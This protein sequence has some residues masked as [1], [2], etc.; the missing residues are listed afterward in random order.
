MIKT[1]ATSLLT[2]SLLAALAHGEEETPW[3]HP[4]VLRAAFQIGMTPDQQPQFREAVREFLEGLNVDV[5]RL[6]NSRDLDDLPRKIASK[7]RARVR[8]MDE[9]MAE[10]LSEDQQAG[11]EVYR[12]LLLDKMDERAARRRLR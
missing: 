5:N 8:A 6:L 7:R 12:D 1:I 3:T 11:Y 10:F 4:E 9:Q 2:L